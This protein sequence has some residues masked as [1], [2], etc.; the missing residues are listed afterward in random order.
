[1][2][3]LHG[4]RLWFWR[5]A[6]SGILP[7]R[8]FSPELPPPEQRAAKQPPLHIEIVSHCWNYSHLLV[9][10]LSSLI[11]APPRTTTVTMTVFYAQEDAATVALLDFIAGHQ[12]PGLRWNWQVLPREKLFRRS[13]GRNLAALATRADWVWFTDCDLVP[14]PGCLDNLGE[15]LAG[16]RDALVFPREERVTTLLAEDDEMLRGEDEWLLKA[17]DPGQF[18][19]RPIS[20]ATGP[21]QITHGDVAR[22]VGYCRDIGLY[23]EPTP[24]FAKCHEDRAFR[25]LLRTHGVPIDLPGV[26]RIRHAEKGRYRAGAEARLRGGLRRARERLSGQPDRR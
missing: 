9:Y 7:A 12:V 4:L 24:R 2:K 5:I 1:M 15:Q 25:W 14:A 21:L 17:I 16:R 23:Q 22:A 18:E 11:L 3:L 19:A 10:Q 26:H 6:A 13:I 20:R 8:R